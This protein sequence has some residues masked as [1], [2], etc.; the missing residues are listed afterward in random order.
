MGMELLLV[1]RPTKMSIAYVTHFSSPDSKFSSFEKLCGR[2][3]VRRFLEKLRRYGKLTFFGMGPEKMFM[4]VR[5]STT[6]SC[7]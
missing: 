3:I 7:S 1:G 2:K 5:V 6:L 4:H